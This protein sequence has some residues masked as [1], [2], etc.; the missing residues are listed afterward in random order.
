[1]CAM[2]A[3]PM[4]CHQPAICLMETPACH[5][6]IGTIVTVNLCASAISAD[7]AIRRTGASWPDTLLARVEAL[8][9]IQTLNARLL[10][11]HTATEV[12][13]KWCADHKMAS[14]GTV[15]ARRVNG[16]EKPI[17]AEQR[18]RLQI[19][20]NEAVAYRYVQ[21]TC[22]GHILVEA[23]NWYVPSRLGAEINHVLA[24]TNTPFGRAVKGLKPIREN[25]SVEILWKPLP[26]GWELGSAPADRPQA[27]LALPWRLFQHR[28][29]L[30]NRTHA[31]FSEV[32]E[33][34]TREVLA[35]GPPREVPR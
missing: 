2:T 34:Y 26:D 3:L 9:L 23:D 7:P 8:A 29:V 18:Q 15:H 35:F 28:A 13:D 22:G 4:V 33:V 14:D 11:A 30:Y 31:P 32:S 6:W 24:T 16:L 27:E 1:M 17:T 12:L 25:I 20:P 21:L 5:G 19:G 10:G